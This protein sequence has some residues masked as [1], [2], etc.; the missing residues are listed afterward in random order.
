MSEE[1]I[2][3]MYDVPAHAEAAI[4]DLKAANVPPNAISS[5]SQGRGSNS[6]YTRCWV[7]GPRADDG[8]LTL[9]AVVR[10]WTEVL[11]QQRGCPG[12]TARTW[13]FRRWPARRRS[14]IWLPGTG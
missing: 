11:A 7:G 4:R 10:V 1:T 3:A 8:T 9:S 13:Q 14:A 12:V 6:G 5:H 2:V